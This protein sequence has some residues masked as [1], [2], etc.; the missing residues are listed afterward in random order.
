MKHEQAS[1]RSGPRWTRLAGL[2]VGS[3]AVAA[4]A[5]SQLLRGSDERQAE[6]ARR[7]LTARTGSQPKRFSLDMLDG[8]PE[9]AQRYLRFAIR[10][11]T[12][13][14]TTALIEMIGR[15][16]LGDSSK[17][18]YYPMRA[19]QILVPPLGFVWV[20]KIGSGLMR[21]SGSD[22]LVDERAW[23]RFWLLGAVPLVRAADT[24]D[25]T[26]S[27]VGR[28]V[29]EALWTPAALLPG[30]GMRWEAADTNV[31]RAMFMIRG[32]EH[33]VDIRV[34]PDGRPLEVVVR[35][36]SNV[37]PEKAFR[38]QPSGATIEAVGTFGGFTVPTRLSGGNHFG[39]PDYF[40]FYQAEVTKVA[41]S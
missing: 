33:R 19:R 15:F 30:N 41:Y 9:P 18:S 13:L 38:W 1:G 24:P 6:D 22:A 39:T 29:G 21:M 3:A 11:G 34:A 7:E 5:G 14:R 17:H 4:G 23:T 28:M 25:L 12:P 40:P 32:E 27:A 36:W 20:P 10:P 37:N 8:L 16:G 31:A 26:R 35:R 2:I